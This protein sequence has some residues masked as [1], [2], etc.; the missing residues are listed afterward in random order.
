MSLH[1][2][3]FDASECAESRNIDG[4]EIKLWASNEE[5]KVCVTAT[6][7]DSNMNKACL[8]TRDMKYDRI[9]HLFDDS[10][11]ER[12]DWLNGAPEY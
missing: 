6:D 8:R 12:N 4:T 1:C 3:Y 5:E 10:H 9:M 7:D 11:F 2:E